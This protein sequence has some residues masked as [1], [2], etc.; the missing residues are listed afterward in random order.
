MLAVSV[1]AET[2]QNEQMVER[3]LLAGEPVVGLV[4]LV[5]ASNQPS[6]SVRRR[7]PSRWR[8]SARVVRRQ[9]P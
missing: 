3:A 5:S 7:W 9:E 1:S 4:D 6:W 8:G 2:S